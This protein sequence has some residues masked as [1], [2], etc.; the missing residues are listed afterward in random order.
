MNTGVILTD[1]E[2]LVYQA[3]ID[4]VADIMKHGY[5]W[6]PPRTTLIA[7]RVGMT[8]AK[9]RRV[10]RRLNKVHL[11][12]EEK[13]PFPVRDRRWLSVGLYAR[14]EL[15]SR[16]FDIQHMITRRAWVWE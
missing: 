15:K 2:E 1:D 9:T 10:L 11:I 4:L 13:P 5:I 3:A 6:G 12:L 16:G 8:N 14:Q 7:K